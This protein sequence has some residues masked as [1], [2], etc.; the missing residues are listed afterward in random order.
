MYMRIFIRKFIFEKN[1]NVMCGSVFQIM[2]D[3]VCRCKWVVYACWVRLWEC[4]CEDTMTKATR[5]SEGGSKGCNK[6]LQC[7]DAAKVASQKD[8]HTN[9]HCACRSK[10][11]SGHYPMH[12]R[13]ATMFL[14]LFMIHGH[15]FPQLWK[16]SLLHPTKMVFMQLCRLL[17]CIRGRTTVS[18][19]FL[20]C[21]VWTW[22]HDHH[23]FLPVSDN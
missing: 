15:L 1:Q 14:G 22:T 19:N 6:H 18:S 12:N 9:L 11:M 8:E 17:V 5:A 23:C 20:F 10:N 13:Y 2:C 3:G 21:S 4:V 7:M 16:T